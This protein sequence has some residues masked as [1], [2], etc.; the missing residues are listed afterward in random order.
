MA[1]QPKPAGDTPT[2]PEAQGPQGG[3]G[4]DIPKS[5]TQQDVDKVVET[6]LAREREKYD[7]SLSD[8]LKAEREDWDKQ[9]KMTEAER[10]KELQAKKDK[11]FTERETKLTFREN[12]ALAAERF[13]EFNIPVNE[14][15]KGLIDKLTDTN[16]ETQESNL[17]AFKSLFDSAVKDGIASAMKGKAPADPSA[18]N[19]SNPEKKEDEPA[20][21]GI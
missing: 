3:T 4:T 8:K 17:K 5:F 7:K 19:S 13:A 2:T 15:T 6:R 14:E 9:A 21:M 18:G 10:E 11:E 20:F 16:L 12:R 1:E